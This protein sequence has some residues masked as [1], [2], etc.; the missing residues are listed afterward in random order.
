[1]GIE[2][3]FKFQ[4]HEN[5]VL[6]NERVKLMPLQADDLEN[7][8]PFSTTEPELWTYSLVSA[9]GEAGMK[10]YIA[11]AI[12]ERAQQKSYPFIVIDKMTDQ[13]AGCTRF[14][15]M[16]LQNQSLQL[17]YTWYG[18]KFHGTG[19]N[20]NCKYLLLQFAFEKMHIERVEFRADANNAQ[21]IAAMKG[22]GA[23]VEGVL[24]A[25]LPKHDE[26]RRDSIVLSILKSEW[27]EIVKPMLNQKL[28]INA[29]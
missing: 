29:K 9:A 21:S 22:I 19:L 25:H 20:Q 28:E 24:R 15:D 8:L 4:F 1:M 26:G 16:Q 3:I 12:L 18:K 7:L 2:P 13:V 10:T 11:T 6:E 27:H 23:T 5:Y 14:Y 17:G